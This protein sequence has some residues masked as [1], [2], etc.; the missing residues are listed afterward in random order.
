MV[1][2]KNLDGKMGLDGSTDL[3]HIHR[4]S[5]CKDNLVLE[6]DSYSVGNSHRKIV[7]V[8][9]HTIRKAKQVGN[10]TPVVVE[11]CKL[12]VLGKFLQCHSRSR[13]RGIV[14]AKLVLHKMNRRPFYDS[15]HILRKGT[16]LA[17]YNDEGL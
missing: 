8:G 13:F 6:I 17:S 12:F 11:V 4:R 1:Y 5:S 9:F 16:G 3:V 10:C 15:V 7:A 2:A 14:R